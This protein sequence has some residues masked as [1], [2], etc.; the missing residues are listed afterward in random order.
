MGWFSD[1][2][3]ISGGSLIGPAISGGLSL[4][5]GNRQNA[6]NSAT[7]ASNNAFTERMSGTAHQR[8]VADL[9]AAGLNPI[10][11]ATGGSGAVTPAASTWQAQNALDASM[12]SARSAYDSWTSADQKRA[13]TRKKEQDTNIDSPKEEAAKIA[14]KAIKE[15]KAALEKAA[16]QLD[17]IKTEVGG[18]VRDLVNGGSSAAGQAAISPTITTP[19]KAIRPA[20]PTENKEASSNSSSAK[21]SQSVEDRIKRLNDL[22]EGADKKAKPKKYVR[23]KWNP[24]SKR[25]DIYET[26]E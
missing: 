23:M 20:T 13:E 4:L 16:H 6:T 3:G 15:P 17:A 14:A 9:R 12:N 8:E 7:A 18:L 21:S 26:D 19:P 11:S 22:I 24:V 25:H 5:G 1:L 2:T 10:L